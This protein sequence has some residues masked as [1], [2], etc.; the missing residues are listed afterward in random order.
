MRRIVRGASYWLPP[1]AWMG[2]IYVLSDQPDLP[3]APGPWLDMAL[4]KGAHAAAYGILAWFY[5]RLLRH[6]AGARRSGTAL[7]V[8]S[9]ALVVMYALSDEYHQTFV[10][11]RNGNWFDVGV[12]SAGAVAA[13]LLDRWWERR[14]SER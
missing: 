13:M 9:I 7:R 12:D 4:K 8:V 14:R 11:G 2:L 10:P 3:H 5:L 6:R 1:L